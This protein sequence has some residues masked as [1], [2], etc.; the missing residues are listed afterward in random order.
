M[1]VSKD[2][3]CFV[4]NDHPTGYSQNFNDA[5]QIC[6]TSGYDGVLELRHEEDAMF[7]AKIMYC[8]WPDIWITQPGI[9]GLS[10]LSY[11]ALI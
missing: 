8:A 11:I 9:G 2:V 1:P 7:M 4:R 5:Q 3:I 6:Q 10:I